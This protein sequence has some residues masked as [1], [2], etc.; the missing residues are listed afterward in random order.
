[1]WLLPLILAVLGLSCCVYLWLELQKKLS[2]GD[3]RTALERSSA[4]LIKTYEK[5]LREIETEWADMY[6]KF[7][8]LAGRMDKSR[9]ILQN[10][11]PKPE[12]AAIARR[13]DLIRKHRG[14]AINE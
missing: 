9:G 11:N 8:R 4:E 3:I 7:N 5:Q 14:G 13:S 10:E 2:E 12:P 6:Q 1:M